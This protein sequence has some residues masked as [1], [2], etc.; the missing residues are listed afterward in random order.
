LAG[1][2]AVD[3]RHRGPGH[4]VVVAIDGA[5]ERQRGWA[6][7]RR[8]RARRG[9]CRAG[10]RRT[11][12]LCAARAE[13]CTEGNEYCKSC[14]QISPSIQAGTG[15]YYER[16]W[17]ACAVPD[18]YF[19]ETASPEGDRYGS[20]ARCLEGQ[21]RLATRPYRGFYVRYIQITEPGRTLVNSVDVHAV[22]RPGS[23]A[24]MKGQ[25]VPDNV[26]TC[27][28]DISDDQG[29]YI[30]PL[31]LVPEDDKNLSLAQPQND[32]QLRVQRAVEAF[33]RDAPRRAA[34]A[35]WRGG[36]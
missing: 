13:G 19:A 1:M 31:S 18:T 16:D 36:R 21:R 15:A 28:S 24:R 25:L 11:R 14:H 6:R 23:G 30:S 5:T 7:R 17:R 2:D 26:R 34:R 3:D 33:L 35:R 32:Y 27:P 9:R 12:V 4:Y 20:A 8:C 10:E 29:G 22:N